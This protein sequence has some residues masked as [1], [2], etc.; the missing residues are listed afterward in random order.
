MQ[1]VEACFTGLV[2]GTRGASVFPG[3]TFRPDAAVNTSPMHA[4]A[5]TELAVTIRSDLEVELA[6]VFLTT[7]D[8]A[9]GS[10]VPAR[11]NA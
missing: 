6:V 2:F 4:A 1:T 3:S 10:D 8:F 11:G 9:A 7:R 5:A